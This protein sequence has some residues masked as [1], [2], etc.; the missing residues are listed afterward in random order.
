[1]AI[2]V[3]V[4]PKPLIPLFQA[5]GILKLWALQEE[6]GSGLALYNAIRRAFPFEGGYDYSY[7]QSL[8]SWVQQFLSASSSAADYLNNIGANGVVDPSVLPKNF[9]L[10]RPEGSNCGY[11][12]QSSWQTLNPATG[13]VHEMVGH[14]WFSDITDL[15]AVRDTII[16]QINSILPA[17]SSSAKANQVYQLVEGSLSFT[18]AVRIC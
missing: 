5:G 12:L 18:G 4:V 3:N 2:N 13:D 14:N 6:F 17:V 10:R 1:M 11:V 8:V 9:Y 15:G 7:Y 16:N